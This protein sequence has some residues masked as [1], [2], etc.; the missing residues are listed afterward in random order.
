MNFSPSLLWFLAGVAFL[1]AEFL[2]P[3]FILLF[4]TIGCWIVGVTVWLSDINLTIQ[5]LIFITSSLVLL[6]AL[7]KYF[8]KTFKGSARDNI[9]DRY[10][11][12]KIG[13]TGTVTKAITPN[14]PGEIK[15]MGSFWKA[16]SDINIEE[17]QPV[18][19]ESHESEDGLTL[20]VKPLSGRKK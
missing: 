10:S 9:D 20:I 7:R 3:G 19:V 18:V 8:I 17:G 16:V 2:A 15:V 13:K 5:I 11:D 12:S 6:F 1:I 14:I 4:F